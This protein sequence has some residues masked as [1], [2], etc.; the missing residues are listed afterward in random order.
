MYNIKTQKQNSERFRDWN[1]LSLKWKELT[2]QFICVTLFL[3]IYIQQLQFLIS[4]EACRTLP[5]NPLQVI[6]LPLA[7]VEVWSIR[8][9][10]YIIDENTMNAK[11]WIACTVVACKVRFYCSHEALRLHCISVKANSHLQL[12]PWQRSCNLNSVCISM[13]VRLF[14]CM[15]FLFLFCLLSFFVLSIRF[16]WSSKSQRSA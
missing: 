16:F 10:L 6:L 8:H 15:F 3:F 7:A 13:P 2:L 4:S 1:L 5:A 11:S 14:F 12:I 9:Q